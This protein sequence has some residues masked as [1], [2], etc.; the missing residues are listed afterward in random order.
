MR[1]G[2]RTVRAAV[3]ASFARASGAHT[4]VD[5][6]GEYV[7][8]KHRDGPGSGCTV[9][10]LA[11]DA[12]RQGKEVQAAFGEGIEA[13]VG[14]LAESMGE[15]RENALRLWSELVGAVV[16]SRSVKQAA[17]ELADEILEATR[18]AL[19]KKPAKKRRPASG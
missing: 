1:D 13:M 11:A 5:A 6:A 17:P 14:L 2:A 18:S 15:P 4:W 7:S 19:P 9:A 3:A 10:A 8:R 16:L 12:G